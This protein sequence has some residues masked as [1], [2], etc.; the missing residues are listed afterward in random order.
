M[1]A[2]KWKC[3][4]EAVLAKQT[5]FKL[6]KGVPKWFERHADRGHAM[7]RG[8]CFECGSPLFLINKANPGAMILFAG[9][10]DDPSW[11][12]PSR[13][14]YV[15]SAQPWDQMDS[16]LPKSDKMPA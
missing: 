12:E 11:Y 14:I 6:E 10:L 9:S 2:D 4:F 13:D 16:S 8:F 5:D 1:P 7:L 3:A 15:K